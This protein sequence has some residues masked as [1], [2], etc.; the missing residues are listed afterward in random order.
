MKISAIDIRKHT[1]E[2]IFRGY[3]PDEVDAF[4]NSLSQEWERFSSENSL[5]KM[6]LEY[7]EKE[8]AKLK[9]IE[10]TLF[11]TLKAAED[12]SRL[13]EK[14]ANENAEKRI[15]ESR[16]TANDLV[17][18]AEDRTNQVIRETEDRLKRFKDEF[19]AEVKLQE[20]DFRAIEN[21]RDNLIVQLSSLANNTI[22]TVERFEQKYDK[23]SVLNKM[24]EIKQHISEIEIPKKAS[25][26]V[27]PRVVPQLEE[28]SEIEEE[29]V[30]QDEK[31]Q[32]LFEVVDA[33]EEVMVD[34][35]EEFVPQIA[36]EDEEPLLVND[37]VEVEPE[38]FSEPEPVEE[39]I[40]YSLKE[41]PKTAAEESAAALAE[42]QRT[43]R[44]REA[45]RNRE[46]ERVRENTP[47]NR[48]RVPEN[49]PKK[50]GGSF[51][52]QI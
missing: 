6:Q 46:T 27:E 44:E 10:S 1:F 26:P 2:K 14:E 43:A 49:Q 40:A 51:F 18:E 42:L 31:P 25:F 12:T 36:Y 47:V 15:E 4:L 13:I 41:E 7:A 17:A 37:V 28:A 30:L 52:D 35:E 29:V 33:E 8:L 22:E 34:E 3:D 24:E 20:R 32:V 19:A 39:E 16:T 11:R 9:D 38:A 45:E 50:T 21:F 48:P 23:Q 5:L